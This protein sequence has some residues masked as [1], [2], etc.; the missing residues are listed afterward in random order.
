VCLTTSP[1]WAVTKDWNDGTG[2]RSTD[3]SWTPA[4]VPGA[5]DNAHITFDDG[6]GRTVTYDYAGPAIVLGNLSVDL[7]GMSTDGTTL[8]M[9]AGEL[10]TS[11]G[12]SIGANGR[13]T[14]TQTGGKNSLNTLAL[15]LGD[16]A[17][18]NGIYN[19]S[20][21]GVL[22]ANIDEI[23]GYSGTGTINQAGGTN[24]ITGPDEHLYL[25]ANG[26]TGNYTLTGGSLS[27]G[28]DEN[29]G[30][31]GTGN[32]DHSA[33]TNQVAGTLDIGVFTAGTGT[34]TLSGTGQ[35]T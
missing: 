17:G 20:G 5:G 35:L 7:T 13:G 33:G 8:T 9:A 11:F 30:F 18:S 12:Q 28:I 2:N 31:F 21:T 23:V 4:G 24:T 26:G 6:V 27:A 29:I 1:L 16:S 34:Y 22:A 32:F 19:L 10:T 14:F 3:A 25:G 15:R